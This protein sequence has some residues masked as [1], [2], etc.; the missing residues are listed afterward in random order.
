MTSVSTSS[1]IL[2]RCLN[3]A[4]I[5]R[6]V[7]NFIVLNFRPGYIMLHSS[8]RRRTS[9]AKI[10]IDTHVESDSEFILPF[11]RRGVLDS[12][13]DTSEF[14]ISSSQ[15]QIK[16]GGSGQNKNVVIKKRS[17]TSKP[18]QAS[19]PSFDTLFSIPKKI[20][21]EAL[22]QVS[23]SALVKETKSD[24]DMRINQIRFMSSESALYSFARFF[25]STV[26]VDSPI[27][28]CSIVSSDIPI[29]R[30]FISK[31]ESDSISIGLNESNTFFSSEDK[32]F[33]LSV[34][35]IPSKPHPFSPFDNSLFKSRITVN[36]P[37]LSSS[38]DWIIKASDS[39]QR[40]TLESDSE[41]LRF[42]Q[43]KDELSSIPILSHDGDHIHMDFPASILKSI[44]SYVNSSSTDLMYGH[45]TMKTLLCVPSTSDN[46]KSFHYL[47]SM[48]PRLWTEIFSIA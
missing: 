37:S 34:S 29:I 31:I 47:Q 48:K 42:V 28:D 16:S 26:Y 13:L 17:T 7:S 46:I 22:R 3:V 43:S 45:P 36:T 35:K 8:D 38:L 30:S 32:S 15:M 44:I 21:D 14:S 12:K 27:K 9:Y 1:S 24:D 25:A 39:G 5:I 2:S 40:V 6:P 41:N 20:L 23:C 19:F 11:E 18:I 33:I 4:S 10:F